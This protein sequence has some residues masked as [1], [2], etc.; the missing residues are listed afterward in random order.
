MAHG[1]VDGE[2]NGDAGG[3]GWGDEPIGPEDIL[4]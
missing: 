2:R 4:G 3:E 1:E